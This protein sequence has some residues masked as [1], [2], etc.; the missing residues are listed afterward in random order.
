MDKIFINGLNV[1][2]IIGT[3]PRE[4][5]EKQTITLDLVI[6]CNMEKPGKSDNL[7]DAIDYS[8]VEKKVYE[9]VK[10]SSFFLL[11]ALADKVAETVLEFAGVHAV[12]IRIDKPAAAAYS[13]SIAIE[14]TRR[15]TPEK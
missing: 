15:R 5:E 13:K 2:T 3:L 7:F 6:E 4:R 11:E 9:T 14:I 10:G 12:T 8:A 1:S